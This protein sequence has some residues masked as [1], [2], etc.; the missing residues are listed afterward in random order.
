MIGHEQC[1]IKYSISSAAI[2]ENKECTY[3]N[4]A[5]G[6]NHRCLARII[7]HLM[8]SSHLHSAPHEAHNAANDTG[9]CVKQAWRSSGAHL[10]AARCPESRRLTPTMSAGV[11]CS[12][13]RCS[14][15]C[16]AYLFCTA[17]FVVQ[18]SM[19]KVRFLTALISVDVHCRC[20]GTN[21]EV[22]D[23]AATLKALCHCSCEFAAAAKPAVRLHPNLPDTRCGLGQ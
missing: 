22:A 2:A 8:I 21:A 20:K 10:M 14:A 1:S 17:A 9:W 3:A 15:R 12:P 13:S 19:P 11:S 5:V 7:Q 4:P 18:P 6:T 16:A 23:L